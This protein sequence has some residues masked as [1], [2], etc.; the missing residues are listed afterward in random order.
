MHR[1]AADIDVLIPVPLQA[2]PYARASLD[3]SLRRYEAEKTNGGMMM[4]G[5]GRSRVIDRTP[6]RER[7]EGGD[8][9][10]AREKFPLSHHKRGTT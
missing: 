6:R 9:T 7:T 5:I 10:L 3:A 4:S 8:G 2:F 1:V